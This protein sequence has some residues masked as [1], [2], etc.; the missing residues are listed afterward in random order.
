MLNVTVVYPDFRPGL[1]EFL[2]G[3]TPRVVVRVRLVEIPAEFLGCDYQN[4]EVFQQRFRAWIGE[5]WQR[6]DAEL[7]A[8]IERERQLRGSA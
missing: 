4:D 2:C 6:K 8:L 7:D 5:L 1:W 3:K